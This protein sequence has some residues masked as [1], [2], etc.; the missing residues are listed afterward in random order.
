MDEQHTHRTIVSF[1]QVIVFIYSVFHIF[2][3]VFK[4]Q[5]FY[6]LIHV[7]VFLYMFH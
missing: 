6:L 5:L 2:Y 7:Y 1:L 4:L 3:Y